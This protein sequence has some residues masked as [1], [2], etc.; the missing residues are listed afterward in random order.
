[1]RGAGVPVTL[2][3]VG[4][5]WLLWHF[6]LLPDVDWI[7]A[8]GLIAGGLAVLLLDGVTKQSVVTGPFLIAGGIAWALHERWRVSWTLLVPALLIALGLLMLISR[9]PGIPDRRARG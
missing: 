9:R 6:R 5:A 7:I 3:I 8:G 2:I 4:S 1:M